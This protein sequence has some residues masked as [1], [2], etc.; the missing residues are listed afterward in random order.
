[1]QIFRLWEEAK[2]QIENQCTAPASRLIK[3]LDPFFVRQQCWLVHHHAVLLNFNCVC[4]I[5]NA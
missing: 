5:L 3:T 1:M 2:V 4:Q